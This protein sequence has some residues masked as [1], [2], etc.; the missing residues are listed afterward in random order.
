[1]NEIA[2]KNN[3][4]LAL[5]FD[6]VLISLSKFAVSSLA[7]KACL[8]LEVYDLRPQIEYSLDLTSNAKKIIENSQSS[9]PVVEFVDVEQIFKSRILSAYEIVELAKNLKTSRLVKNF[10]S[11]FEY[12]NFLKIVQNFYIDKSFEDEIFSIFDKDLNLKDCASEKLKSL[13][14]AYR[15]NKENLRN[16][17]NN[18]LQNNSFVENLQ[19]TVVSIR[20]DR[21]VFQVKAS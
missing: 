6:K 20:E 11:K 9:I 18:L 7:K 14:L 4:Y 16:A 5:E 8:N 13:R 2:L 19:D 1:M 3:H 10:L 15:D 17:I 12:E 21:P